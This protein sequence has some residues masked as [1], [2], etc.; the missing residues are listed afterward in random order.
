MHS[1]PV[2]EHVPSPSRKV[3]R[4]QGMATKPEQLSSAMGGMKNFCAGKTRVGR[5]GLGMYGN[6]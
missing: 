4:L 3:P 1:S 6:G 2:A 5:V